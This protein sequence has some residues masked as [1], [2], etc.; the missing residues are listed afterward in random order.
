MNMMTHG[1]KRFSRR[2]FWGCLMLLSLCPLWTAEIADEQVEYF[3]GSTL[4]AGAFLPPIRHDE[5]RGEG[6]ANYLGKNEALEATLVDGWARLAAEIDVSGYKLAKADLGNYYIN[7]LCKHGE[8]FHVNSTNWGIVSSGGVVI[9]VRPQYTVTDAAALAEMK[10]ELEQ[11]VQNALSLVSD[12]MSD[13]EKALVLHDFVCSNCE[14]DETASLSHIRDAYGALVL[15][16]AVCAGYAISY[17]HL[18]RK[19][20]VPVDY[21]ASD[22]M[23]HAWNAVYIDGEWYHVDVT[24][25][26]PVTSGYSKP[27]KFYHENF[28]KSDTAIKSLEHPVW[29]YPLYVCNSTR[30]DDYFWNDEESFASGAVPCFAGRGYAV[31]KTKNELY[32]YDLETG[33][34][35]KVLDL[36][37]VRWNVWGKPNSYW[38]G[39]FYQLAT[40]H[41]LL[42][43]STRD[44]VLLCDPDT[45]ATTTLTA[46][47][48]DT[49]YCYGLWLSDGANLYAVIR[50]SPGGE[51]AMLPLPWVPVTQVTVAP[52]TQEYDVLNAGGTQSL[53]LS[54]MVAPANASWQVLTWSSDNEAVATVDS[55]GQATISLAAP[56]TATIYATSR[57]NISGQ[58]DISVDYPPIAITVTGSSEVGGQVSGGGVFDYG[59]TTTLTAVPA[60]DYLFSGW[61]LNDELVS[62]EESYAI[63]A[64]ADADYLA[65]FTLKTYAVT[66]T[67]CLAD[68]SVAARGETV[69]VTA[70]L[71]DGALVSDYDIEWI[72]A[73][74]VE[75][76]TGDGTASFEMPAE[77]VE[78]NCVATLKTYGVTATGGTADKLIAARG[79]MVT[80]TALLPEEALV[81]DYDFAWSSV[82]TVEFTV[83]EGTAFFTMPAEA[84]SVTCSA[85][86]KTY[87]V[88][89]SG[90]TA[91]KSS[92]TRGETVTVTATLPED[93]L[94]SDYDIEWTSVPTVEF[95]EGDGT[96]SFTMPTEAVSVS[97]VTTLKTYAITVTGATADKSS[98]NRG[99][100]VTVT[101][102]L[103]EDALVSDY[104]FEWTF[105]PSI[106]FAEGEGMVSFEMPTE[107]VEVTCVATLKTYVVT[108]N[109]CTAD[110]EIAARGETVMVTAMLP[111]GTS[112]TDFDLSW[113]SVP[114]VDFIEIDAGVVRFVMP[115]SEIAVTCT[116][117]LDLYPVTVVGATA[118]KSYA[119]AGEMVTATATLPDGA[120]VSDY[121]I[122]WTLTPS[123]D[124][125]TGEGT[126]SFEMPDEAV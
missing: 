42:A 51:S 80:M 57:E 90:A 41:G 104:D 22:S 79:E 23:N 121:D 37:D 8:I 2:F 112:A 9:K 64:Y 76:T 28:L 34:G 29:D 124:F 113:E 43:I 93:S 70:T 50:Q 73:P 5:L 13:L 7:I 25:D 109:G 106:E 27:E 99:E 30:F 40:F 103:P 122:E 20:G 72:F 12:N 16:R 35:E 10:A 55:H 62:S 98:A 100:T 33:Q 60:E 56:G 26:D 69:M 65:L 14:Y 1:L 107:A 84:V 44:S 108:A 52:A 38:T 46:D 116:G 78:V 21:I 126:A 6:E 87:T 4:I 123:V 36:P 68:K 59:T 88:M 39:K 11:A 31:S 58:C 102:L 97:C 18:L 114:E 71:P 105:A 83:N 32:A 94:A 81:S 117:A 91:D 95:T 77:A 17:A 61:F 49:G 67:G 86:P 63:T 125:T 101:A 19:V 110:K 85:T 48:P 96:A 66:T 3:D 15:K 53:Q 24:W 74:A 120:L 75:F 45:M 111:E 119:A 54:A 92:A 115:A 89:V 118:K 47:L 82:P